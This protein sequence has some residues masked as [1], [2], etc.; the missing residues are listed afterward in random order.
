MWTREERKLDW[1]KFKVLQKKEELNGIL[2]K[3]KNNYCQQ[4]SYNAVKPQFV[5]ADVGLNLW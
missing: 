3:K 1:T 2:P 4:L 5:V